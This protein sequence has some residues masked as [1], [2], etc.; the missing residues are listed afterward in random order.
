MK[1]SIKRQFAATFTA[2]MAA[3]LFICWVINH[4]FL[5]RY[6]EENREKDIMDTYNVL[7][8]AAANAELTSEDFQI[9]LE[10][11]SGRYNIM[12]VI[13]DVIGGII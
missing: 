5:P 9:A 7:N 4:T 2:L 12:G 3:T 10:K 13:Q 1:H 6:Y 11:I 8:D